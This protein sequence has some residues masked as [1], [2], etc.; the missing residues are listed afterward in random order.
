MRHSCLCVGE[1]VF[2]EYTRQFD[3]QYPPYKYIPAYMGSNVG[4]SE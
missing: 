1:V 4:D 2:T 3:W